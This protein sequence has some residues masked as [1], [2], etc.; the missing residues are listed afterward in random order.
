MSVPDIELYYY[1]GANFTSFNAPIQSI[2]ISRGRS[3]QLNRFESGSA[4]VNFRNRDRK[5]DPLNDDSAYQ[6]LVVPRLPV[7]IFADSVPIYSG[8]VKDWDIEYDLE[9]QYSATA[10]CSDLFTIL[11][12]VKFLEDVETV[13]ESCDD[14]LNFV[15]NYFDFVFDTD[16]DSGNATLGAFTIESGTQLLDYVFNVASSDLGNIFVTADNVLTFI[17]KFG[18]TPVS[19]LTFADDGTGIPYSSLINEFGDE[20]FYN[21]VSV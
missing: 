21:K 20:L 14:R 19:E 5:L 11:A 17:G 10:Y 15:L 2:S 3:R 6:D 16:F 12:N 7:K 1:D 8:I 18:R 9:D 4:I 13:V